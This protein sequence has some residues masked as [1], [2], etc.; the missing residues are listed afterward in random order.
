MVADVAAGVA[1]APRCGAPPRPISQHVHAV[2]QRWPLGARALRER[3]VPSA[4]LAAAER[5]PHRGARTVAG[6]T[7]RV[8]VKSADINLSSHTKRKH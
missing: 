5:I 1:A 8:M 6:Q 4:V 2:P 3:R 7:G